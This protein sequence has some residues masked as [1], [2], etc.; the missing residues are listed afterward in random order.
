MDCAPPLVLGAHWRIH[1]K[2]ISE[3][4]GPQGRADMHVPSQRGR[5]A[6]AADLGSCQSI[7]LVVR[8]QTAVLP[9]D[10]DAEQAC[11]MQIVIVFGRE[12]RLTVVGGRAA[13]KDGLA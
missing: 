7:S 6:I 8:A 11:A 5:A 13:R 10:R 3:G 9:R 1:V 12:G 4:T 2:I